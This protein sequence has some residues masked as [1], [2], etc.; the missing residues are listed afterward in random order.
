[1]KEI[2]QI[3]SG[4]NITLD[5]ETIGQEV[6]EGCHKEVEIVQFPLS[7]GPNKGKVMTGRKGCICEDIRLA[8]E[9]VQDHENMQKKKCFDLFNEKS[10]INEVLKKATLKNYTP[11]T[12]SQLKALEWAVQYC[13]S[14]DPKTSQNA[15]FQGTY[16]LGKSHLSVGIVRYLLKQGYTCIFTSV[17][18]LFTKI[19][20]T[21]DKNSGTREHELLEALELA[22]L[23]VLDDLGAEQASDWQLS[24][25]FEVIDTR[26]GKPT[27]YTTNH[28]SMTLAE[29]VGN[30]NFDRLLHNAEILVLDGSSYRKRQHEANF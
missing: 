28:N 20:S 11:Q 19:K 29:Q 17:P 18:K 6:C 8:R 7:I 16:G 1:M 30:R 24:K 12:A 14:F 2:Q 26:A 10:L 21:Y 15:L 3:L 13:K 22:D 25:L 5:F 27:I 4:K 23:L 9:A